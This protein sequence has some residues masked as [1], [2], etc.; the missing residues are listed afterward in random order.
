MTHEVIV[1]EAILYC[2]STTKALYATVIEQDRTCSKTASARSESCEALTL[3]QQLACFMNTRAH[4]LH[5][6]SV[7]V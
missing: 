6:C 3:F 2:V 5:F 1:L 4:V 7:N